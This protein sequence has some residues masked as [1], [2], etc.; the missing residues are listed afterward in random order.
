MAALVMAVAAGAQAQAQ[1]APATT[2]DLK[3]ALVGFALATSEEKD[4]QQAGLMLAFYYY[5][6]LSAVPGFQLERRLKEVADAMTDEAFVAES[7]RCGD[8]LAAVGDS[9]QRFGQSM[10]AKP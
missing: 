7:R 2:G 9:M 8:E 3:C 10:D 4:E 5:G 6:R 1:E